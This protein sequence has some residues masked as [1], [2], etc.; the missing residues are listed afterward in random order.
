MISFATVKN[1]DGA[2]ERRPAWT[3]KQITEIGVQNIPT[4]Q[5]VVVFS[6]REQ[7]LTSLAETGLVD[8]D[9]LQAAFRDVLHSGVHSATIWIPF[10]KRAAIVPQ[11]ILEPGVVRPSARFRAILKDLGLGE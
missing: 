1:R 3:W 4:I 7:L 6:D 11:P 10:E 8:Q 9:G 5:D 2:Y